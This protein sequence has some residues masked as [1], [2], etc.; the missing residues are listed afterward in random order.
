MDSMGTGTG[1]SRPIAVGVRASLDQLEKAW[2]TLAEADPL[3]AVCVSRDR[4]G[5]R[6]DLAEFMASGRAEIDL[7]VDRLGQLG[8][9]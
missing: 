5:G 6:W 4:R 2:T 1:A 8:I 7:A 9:C 3:W